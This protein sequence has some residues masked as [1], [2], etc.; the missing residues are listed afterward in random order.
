MS[1][2]MS[3]TEIDAQHAE[4]LPAR[5]VLSGGGGFD[6]DGTAGDAAGGNG[7]AGVGVLSGISVLSSGDTQGG[8]GGAG[9]AASSV[10]NL[11]GGS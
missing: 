11:L 3:F 4:L 2:A 9:G 8:V 10:G 6:V 1:D 7:G 5:T